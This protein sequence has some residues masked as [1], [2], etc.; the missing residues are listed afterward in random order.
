MYEEY[1]GLR[2]KPFSIQPD[3]GFIYFLRRHELAY[4]MLEYGI[5][6]R[7]GFSV[8]TGEVGCGKTSLIRHLLNNLDL[9]H[10]VG[11]VSNTHEDIADLLEWI[12]LAFGEPFDGLSQVALY[13]RFQNFLIQQYKKGRRVV[14]IVDEAQ[15]LSVSALES[16]RMLSNINADK[17]Q[18][19]QIIL[20]GQPEL[21][22][23]LAMPE[24]RQLAQRVA[25]DFH[26]E[27]L[28]QDEVDG[29]IR[30]RL[31]VVGREGPLF[32]LEACDLIAWASKGIP[33]SINILSDLALVY[34]Y[35]MEADK[36]GLEI[37]EEVLKDR[38]DY[39]VLPIRS[40]RGRR[41][42]STAKSGKKSKAK[43]RN[44]ESALSPKSSEET[45]D[46]S[47]TG[48]LKVQS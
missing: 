47:D 9:N 20:V 29:Y 26:L 35:S 41:K 13:D 19:L 46:Q 6:N 38:H 34:G 8:I 18:L 28:K 1:Y 4:A 12:M 15:N 25:V 44:S 43:S 3:P 7:A 32:T 45:S 16:M 5:Q 17:D 36:I 23:K 40:N 39:G 24:L 14:L 37:I 42:K 21:K 31:E 33:R 10:T 30:H 2:E 22:E 11:L 48:N 27:P